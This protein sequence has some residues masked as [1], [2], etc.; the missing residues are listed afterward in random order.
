MANGRTHALAT[1]AAG[2]AGMVALAISGDYIGAAG[3]A[4]GAMLGLIMTPDCDVDDGFYGLAVLR[5][6]SPLLSVAWQWYWKPYA[7][8][9]SHR[10][11][12]SHGVI[13]GT[14]TRLVYAFWWFLLIY[15]PLYVSPFYMWLFVSL[16]IMDIVH[17]VMDWRIWGIAGI[18]RQ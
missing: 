9:V 1:L 18:F 6:V 15:R 2:S 3:W 10:S 12:I 11:I 7:R 5:E 14:F 13:I 4:S 16:A 8:I 17:I